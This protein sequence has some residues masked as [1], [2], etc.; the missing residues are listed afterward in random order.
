[1]PPHSTKTTRE[2]YN[3]QQYFDSLRDELKKYSH[4]LFCVHPHDIESNSWVRNIKKL[5]YQYVSGATVEDLNALHRIRYLFDT[6]E[7][8]TSPNLGSHLPYAAY[9]G[10]RVSIYGAR[11]KSNINNY[12]NDQWSKQNWEAVIYSFEWCES[13]KPH[14]TYPFLFCEP[15]KSL[16]QTEWAK[17]ILGETFKLPMRKIKRVFGWSRVASFVDR[18]CGKRYAY[19]NN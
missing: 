17:K 4:V 12:I 18:L 19:E 7:C 8:V 16:F 10:C 2:N 15:S 5:G 1:M 3:E 13:D 6:F 11:P 9:C 14:K